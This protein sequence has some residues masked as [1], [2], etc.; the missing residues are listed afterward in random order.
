LL[1]GR[2]GHSSVALSDNTILVMGG[3]SAY[4]TN[5][6]SNDVWKSVDGGS[7]WNLVTNT[8]WS[9]GVLFSTDSDILIPVILY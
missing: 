1:K 9:L 2:S 7:T 6:Y 3:V 8:A 5:A 4:T